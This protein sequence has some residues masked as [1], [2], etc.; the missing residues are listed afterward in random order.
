MI[1][2]V[3]N[4]L[5]IVF[6]V[7]LFL[8][9]LFTSMQLVVYNL[10]YYESHYEKRNITET[11]EMDIENL[12]MV[13]DNMLEYLKDNRMTLNMK[14]TIDG[15]MEEVF[16]EREK[17]H[18]EDVKK[19]FVN[20]TMIRNIGVIYIIV[21]LVLCIWKSKKLLI[22]ILSSIKYVFLGAIGLLLLIGGL[23]YYDF[24]KYFTIFHKI[25]FNNDLW[26]LNP[27]TDI[28]IN[29]VPEIFFF[30]TAMMILIIFSI[31]IILTIIIAEKSK[32]ILVLK[33]QKFG[34][35]LW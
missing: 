10:D 35:N 19:L 1:K 23:L 11:T 21:L 28:L 14:A 12:M 9:L 27:R 20:A 25:F 18:M 31:M 24:N 30:T 2:I 5:A 6:S 34:W 22:R 3:S 4:L 8:V 15:R 16:G 33:L 13:T 7:M 32:K 26:L 29:M 17:L